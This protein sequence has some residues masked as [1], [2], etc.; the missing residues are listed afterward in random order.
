MREAILGNGAEE[1]LAYNERAAEAAVAIAVS[2][3]AVAGVK[4]PPK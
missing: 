4:C 3:L 1:K 2:I